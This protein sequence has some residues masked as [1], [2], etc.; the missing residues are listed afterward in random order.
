MIYYT[1]WNKTEY[2]DIFPNYKKAREY[3]DYQFNTYGIK[4]TIHRYYV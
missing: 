1:V 4:L 2:V 3:V